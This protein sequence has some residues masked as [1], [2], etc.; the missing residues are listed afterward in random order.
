MSAL[1]FSPRQLAL[2]VALTLIW[3]L[4]WPVMKLGVTHYPPLSFRTLSM[5][6]GLPVLWVAVRALKVPL[7]VPRAEWRELGKKFGRRLIINQLRPVLHDI[8][9]DGRWILF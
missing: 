3:G 4:N 5:W 8:T 1:R 9:R 6:I 7:H 2:L